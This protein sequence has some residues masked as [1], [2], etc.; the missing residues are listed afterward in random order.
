MQIVKE[1]ERDGVSYRFVYNQ[2]NTSY[3]SD[4]AVQLKKNKNWCSFVDRESLN[5]IG[6]WLKN[7]QMQTK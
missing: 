4:Y 6:E 1:W 5:L 3:K 7:E 2:K